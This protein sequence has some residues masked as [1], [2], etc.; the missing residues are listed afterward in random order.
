[1]IYAIIHIKFAKGFEHHVPENADSHF[2]GCYLFISVFIF[3]FKMLL[4]L[5]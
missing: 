4:Q 2:M 3:Y 5:P 1:M